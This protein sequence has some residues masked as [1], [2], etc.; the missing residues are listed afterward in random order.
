M[1][2]RADRRGDKGRMLAGKPAIM[3]RD[4]APQSRMHA[5]L[6]TGTLTLAA[7][8]ITAGALRA[9][10]AAPAEV[11]PTAAPAD[12]AELP[13][14]A[15]TGVII[16]HGIATFNSDTL[17]H[18]ADMAYLPYV[19]PDAPKGGE[20]SMQAIQDGYDSMNPFS[21]QGRAAQGATMMLEGILTGTADEIGS[22]YCFMCTT[23]EFPEDRSWVIFNLRDDVRFSDGSA[24]TAEDV[25]FSYN[26]FLTKGLAE[27]RPQLEA[28]VASAEVLDPLRVKFTFQPGV[29]SRHLPAMVGGLPVLS[30]ADYEARDMDLEQGSMQ[31]FLG[32]GAYVPVLPAKSPTT[33][34]YRRNPDYWAQDL[35]FG[36]GMNNYDLIRYEYFAEANA[37]F[38]GFK[39]GAYTFRQEN[40]ARQWSLNY[41][42]PAVLN[43]SVRK[44][45]LPRDG[46][47]NGQSWVF[48]LRRGIWQDPRLREAIAILFNFEWS[49][50]T[51]FFGKYQRINSFWENSWLQA[52]GPPAPDEVALLQPLVGEGLLPP[53]IL[54]DAPYS[55]PVSDAGKLLDRKSLLKASKLLDEAGWLVDDKGIRRNAKGVALRLEILDDNPTF[56]KI[57]APF[58]E[59]LRAVG[60][61]AG[62]NQ[63]DS[64][65]Y[66]VR[67]RNPDYD[68][69]FTSTFFVF[70]YFPDSGLRQWIGSAEADV[71][72]RNLAGLKDPAVDRLINVIVAAQSRDEVTTAVHALDRVLRADRFRVP[73]WHKPEVWVAYYDMYEHPAV[74]PPYATGELSWWWVNAEKAAALKASGALR[75]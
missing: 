60:I 11:T 41:D 30:K 68:F 67:T 14:E 32:T 47:S 26:V 48:N 21:V 7:A 38:E 25:V 73:M 39:G 2:A 54:T 27:F 71:S 72:V 59:N 8:L 62:V 10:E 29:P 65:Q 13:A 51:L 3:V 49:N 19:N 44:E 17:L 70:D 69:D 33:I 46:V 55:Q 75:Q 57:L 37:G 52:E 61:D 64:A 53:G 9:Q 45:E 12:A 56:E 58:V 34:S 24:L 28:Q 16:S 31:P 63:I 6:L 22:S 50:D 43:G 1:A 18:P 66:E 40:V 15:E 74:L 20:F 42:F 4:P 36:I 5:V 35:P 23:M